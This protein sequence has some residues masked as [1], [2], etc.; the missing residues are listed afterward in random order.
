MKV[1]FCS[2]FLNHHQL[3][4]CQKMTE[5][6]DFTFI[7]EKPSEQLR[8]DMGWQDM[9][10]LYPFVHRAYENDECFDKAISLCNKADIVIA[11][12]S[13]QKFIQDRIKQKKIIFYA[14]ERLIK[15]ESLYRKLRA[16]ARYIIKIKKAQKKQY[17]N[18]NAYLLAYGAFVK[19]DYYR[20]LGFR[21]TTF[22][23]GYFPFVEK[24]TLEYLLEQ[25]KSEKIEVLF[26]GRLID[27]KRCDLAIKTVEK[28][29]QQYKNIRFSI[30][31]NGNENVA[32]YKKLTDYVKNKKLES[33]IVFLGIKKPSE[34]I[35]QMQK[36]HIFLFPSNSC[37]GWG[38]VLNEAMASACAC[39]A[40]DKIGSVPFLLKSGINGFVFKN[41][42]KN[43][44]YIKF[45]QLLDNERLRQEMSANAYNTIYNEQNADIAAE[46]LVEVFKAVLNNKPLDVFSDG[47]ASIQ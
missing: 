14:D 10:S 11:G 19:K 45:L 26:A 29:R 28:V 40:S 9:N 41:K 30:I 33:H 7:A 20:Q 3:R 47:I 27:W 17:K 42:C 21:G 2:N 39:L 18:P 4:F 35:E 16:I 12:D 37:E 6:C 5:L 38:C 43:D 8:L 15:A 32:Y 34:V 22:K 13:S 1:V 24:Q 23:L 25:K 46:R 31:G 36:S 44:F